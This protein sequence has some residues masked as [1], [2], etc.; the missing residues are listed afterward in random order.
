MYGALPSYQ[1]SKVRNVEPDRCGDGTAVE[2]FTPLPSAVNGMV[3]RPNR[4]GQDGNVELGGMQDPPATGTWVKKWTSQFRSPLGE[5]I[6]PLDSVV[7]PTDVSQMSCNGFLPNA[8]VL[9]P[10]V[11]H[12]R[13]RPYRHCH[14]VTY[15]W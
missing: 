13:R 6:Q 4:L 11:K 9:L 14:A 1:A 10:L 3:L 8:I 5:F 2:I 15:R 12:F 7:P